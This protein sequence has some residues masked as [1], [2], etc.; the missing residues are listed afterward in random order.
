MHLEDG[1][2]VVTVTVPAGCDQTAIT[3]ALGAYAV[4]WHL[5]VTQDAS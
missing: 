4:R 5:R 2:V 3:A 1:S